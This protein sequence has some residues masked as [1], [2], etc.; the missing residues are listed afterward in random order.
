MDQPQQAGL[1][2]MDRVL[3]QGVLVS[4]GCAADGT[5]GWQ[6]GQVPTLGQAVKSGVS[7]ENPANSFFLLLGLE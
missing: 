3:L 7:V 1:S 5:E 6:V 2:T 4:Q